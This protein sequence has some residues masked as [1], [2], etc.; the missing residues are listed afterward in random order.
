MREPLCRVRG[1]PAPSNP[2]WHVPWCGHGLEGHHHH[3]PKRSQGGKRIVA[4]LC[5]ACH[6]EVDSGYKYGNAVV[7]GKDGYVYILWDVAKGVENLL[8]ERKLGDGDDIPKTREETAEMH[9]GEAASVGRASGG[10]GHDPV[11]RGD[12]SGAGLPE[13]SPNTDIERD[14]LK[15]GADRAADEAGTPIVGTHGTA[16]V[17]TSSLSAAPSA[18]GDT[19]PSGV[20]DAGAEQGNQ[21]ASG[22]VPSGNKTSVSALALTWDAYELEGHRLREQAAVL[23]SATTQF[24][25]RVGDWVNEGEDTFGEKAHQ[26]ISDIGLPYWKVATY[27]SVARRVPP[28]NRLCSATNLTIEHHRVVAALAL[29]EQ[30]PLLER[31]SSESMSTRALKE[32][33]GEKTLPK[34]QRWTL[35]ELKHQAS[36]W[37][38]TL[39]KNDIATFLD[40]LGACQERRDAER[41]IR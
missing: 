30:R 26:L 7:P 18:S 34:V 15:L 21:S 13:V 6:M 40:W 5:P 16:P 39:G 14:V 27:A 20:D 8:I 29:P 25:F 22:P 3:V 12:G 33:T 10:H 38:T 23:Q 36:E 2:D 9:G 41:T 11:H 31:A 1:C 32:A 17:N 4:F 37:I 35:E 19:S 24:A 28:E